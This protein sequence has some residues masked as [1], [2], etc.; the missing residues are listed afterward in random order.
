M[1]INIKKNT[2]KNTILACTVAGMITLGG[3]PSE[4]ALGDRTLYQGVNHP[5][6]KEL[7]QELRKLNFFTYRSNTNYYGSITAKAVKQFQSANGLQADGIFGRMSV[8]ALKNKSNGAATPK[9]PKAS[10]PATT[11]GGLSY[12]RVLSRGSRGTDVRALQTGLKKLG[13]YNMAIDNIFGNGARN[14]VISFQRSQGLAVDGIA[15][16][17]TINSLNN[18]LSGKLTAVKPAATPKPP[19]ANA[20]AST[21]GV[22]SYS[23]VLRQGSRGADV[24]ALQTSLK[25]LGHYNMAIDS[26][27]GNGAKNAV[28]SFQRAQRL[29]VDG[30][31]GRATINSL[32]N[33]LSGKVAAGKPS[34]APAPSRNDSGKSTSINIVNTAKKYLGSRYV[35]GGTSPSGFDCTGFTQYVY[36]Q[37][38]V[39]LPRTTSSQAYVGKSL[40]KSQLQAGDLIIFNNTYRAGPS[41]AGIYIGNGQFIH[42]ANPSRGVRTD[43]INSSYYSSKFA[44]GRRLY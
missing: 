21:S 34:S 11:S 3:N 41:H 14:A 27:F 17:A 35:Y 37:M 10:A 39:S 24:R 25:K 12:G 32:N 2:I 22:L 42:A 38:G 28:M 43:S 13:H 26:V 44:S 20:P 31:V 18:V 8:N 19:K 29:T 40:S 16:R 23:R 33:V 15:G 5:D 4:A 9:P 6:V 7:Q 36:R 1:K 30:I